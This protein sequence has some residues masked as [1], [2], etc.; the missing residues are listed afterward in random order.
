MT[1]H[2]HDDHIRKPQDHLPPA[3]ERGEDELPE[4]PHYPTISPTEDGGVNPATAAE[5]QDTHQ[6]GLGGMTSGPR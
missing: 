2:E 5:T 1:E 6:H 3:S 4:Q